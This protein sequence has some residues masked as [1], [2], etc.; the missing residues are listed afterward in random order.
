[1]FIHNK[2]ALY[3]AEWTHTCTLEDSAFTLL[4]MYVCISSNNGKA[5][6]RVIRGALIIQATINYEFYS[7]QNAYLINPLIKNYMSLRPS[8]HLL[9]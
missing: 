5:K 3:V 4:I 2:H 9:K 1:M 7:H 6:M 8:R